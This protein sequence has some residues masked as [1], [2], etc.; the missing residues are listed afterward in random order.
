MKLFKKIRTVLS[1][2]LI[3]PQLI[4]SQCQGTCGTNLIPN[5]GFELTTAFCNPVLPM[6]DRENLYTNQAAVQSW[7]GTIPAPPAGATPVGGTPDYIAPCAIYYPQAMHC[8]SGVAL[9]GIGTYNV[10]GSN[11][12]IREYIQAQLLSPLTAGHTYCFSITVTTPLGGIDFGDQFGAWFYSAGPV[13]E[14]MNGGSDFFGPGSI[15]N[16]HPQV[17]NTAGDYI[18]TACKIITGTFCAQG[19]E[20]WIMLGNFTDDAGTSF[21]PGGASI[22]GLCYVLMDNL[23]LYEVC[24]NVNIVASAGNINCGQ[25]TT[26]NATT[27]SNDPTATYT[28]Y[29]SNGDTLS[30]PGPHIVSPADTTTYQVVFSSPGTCQPDTAAI[31]INVFCGIST[32]LNDTVICSGECCNIIA[33]PSVGGI[34]PF[35]YT[36]T[37]NIG[38]NSMGPFSVCPTSTSVYYLTVTDATGHSATDSAIVTVLPTPLVNAGNDFTICAGDSAYLTGTASAGTLQW[39]Q[40]PADAEYAVS[41]STTTSYYLEAQDQGCSSFDT[42]NIIVLPPPLSVLSA[43]P[44]LVYEDDPLTIITNA[45]QGA[46]SCFLNF[47]DGTQLTDCYSSIEHTYPGTGTYPLTQIAVNA[48]GC[49][50]TS[51]ISVEV[52]PISVL[53]VPNA[54]SPERSINNIFYAKGTSVSEFNMKIFNRWGELIFESNDLHKGWD[55]TFHNRIVEQDIYVWVISYRDYKGNSKQLKGTVAVVR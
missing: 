20:D 35:T 4:F 18:D 38:G 48:N 27:N 29:G 7:L 45:S 30:G 49:S 25:S 3:I 15:I 26:L 28:W 23:S 2:F 6:N 33:G 32:S 51:S 21:R 22:N 54:F 14:A 42:V 50:D 55:G 24:Q 19:G 11:H 16:A 31:T 44:A 10:I 40:G 37:P 17:Q 13:T 52:A 47:G 43:S 9:T 39:L 8:I 1:A 12:N 53:W 34:A 36:W 46:D 5:P 41:P